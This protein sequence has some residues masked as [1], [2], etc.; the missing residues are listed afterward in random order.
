[1]A[2]NGVR[3]V[4]RQ[5]TAGARW[6]RDLGKVELVDTDPTSIT[7]VLWDREPTFV[8]PGTTSIVLLRVGDD[9]LPVREGGPPGEVFRLES[10]DWRGEHLIPRA[11]ATFEDVRALGSWILTSDALG[12]SERLHR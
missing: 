7:H 1:M 10:F 4:A 6:L 12:W 9:L 11:D 5:H 8:V 3:S 2:L